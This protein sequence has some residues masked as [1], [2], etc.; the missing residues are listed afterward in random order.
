MQK[1][2][3]NFRSR[4]D[5]CTHERFHSRTRKEVRDFLAI[6]PTHAIPLKKPLGIKKTLKW[7]HNNKA[8]GPDNINVN[9]LKPMPKK[10][11]THITKLFNTSLR[12]HHFPES[13]RKV[14]ITMIPKPQ[15]DPLIPQNYRPIS[16]L[17]HA[18]KILERIMLKRL[19]THVK[20]LIPDTQF[21]FRGEH[22]TTLQLFRFIDDTTTRFLNREHTT[23]VFF[24]IEKAF[25]SVW[26]MGLIK[27]LINGGV[28]DAYIKQIKSYLQDRTYRAKYETKLSTSHPMK[29]GVPQGSVLAPTLFN[30]YMADIPKHPK[31]KIA[32]YADDTAIYITNKDINTNTSKLQAHIIKLST[33]FSKWRIKLNTDKTSAITFT[34]RFTQ[35]VTPLI[36]NNTPLEY[37]NQ[38]KYLGLTLDK[39]TNLQ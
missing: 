31:T 13:F 10:G 38:I 24:D 5:D 4:T 32:Q 21:A 34:K 19:D 3:S 35:N 7:V 18:G 29:A 12:L 25:D 1:H 14:H 26:Y 6:P 22:S 9:T 16:L 17:D 11:F 36:I 39:K 37:K 33:W 27:K 20:H 23:A 15:K 2:N 28:P 8:P 30:I